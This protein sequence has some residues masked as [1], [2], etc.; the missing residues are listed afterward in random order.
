MVDVFADRLAKVR[1]RFAAS[2]EGKIDDTYRAFPQLVGDAAV[3]D[4][5]AETY[6]RIHG[7]C[8]VAETVGFTETGRA[9]RKLD[10][11]LFVAYQARRGLNAGEMTPAQ[12]ALH[13]LRE[14]AR[15]ELQ[16]TYARWR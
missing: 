4:V 8:G 2:V 5:V 10:T 12:K 11:I 6:R 9:A 15:L 13:G 7:I 14:A 1:H 16:S 3:P